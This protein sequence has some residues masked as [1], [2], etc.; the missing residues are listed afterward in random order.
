MKMNC[1]SSSE[2][3][4]LL[5]HSAENLIIDIRESYELE[6]GS[7]P[8]VHLPMAEIPHCSET[9]KKNFEK[10]IVVCQSGKRAEACANFLETEFGLNNVHVLEGGMTAW[11]DFQMLKTQKID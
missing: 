10:I 6:N 5:T 7:S 2:V 8:F 3:S 4:K 9:F 11:Q 1:I